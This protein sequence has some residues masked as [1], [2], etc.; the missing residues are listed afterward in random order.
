[1][2]IALEMCKEGFD[3]K[4]MERIIILG[5][6]QTCTEKI[7]MIGRLFRPYEGKSRVSV[8]QLLPAV[9][10][11]KSDKV[12]EENAQ[13]AVNVITSAMLY[14]DIFT[15]RILTPGE[16]KRT[17]RYGPGLPKVPSSLLT[18]ELFKDFLSVATKD[19]DETWR[20]MRP[21]LKRHGIEKA[22]W[23][24]VYDRLWKCCAVV[25]RRAMGLRFDVPFDVLKHTELQ[26]GIVKLM[27]GALGACD[28]K[29][30]REFVDRTY[31]TPEEWVPIAEDLAKKH[32]GVLPNCMW[33]IENGYSALDQA[34]RNYPELF[35]GFNQ[36]NK[37]GKT[38]K[39][40]L[41]DARR[42]T[43]NNEGLLPNYAWLR[44]NGYGSLNAA[45]RFYPSEFT[46]FKQAVVFKTVTEQIHDAEQLAKKQDG[47]LPNSKWL[48]KNGHSKLVSA[49]QNH[50]EEFAHI[51]QVKI[52]KTV[53]EHVQDAEQLAKANGGVLPNPSKLP[54]ALRSAMQGHCGAFSHLEQTKKFKSHEDH[55]RNARRLTKENGGKLPSYQSLI[56][57]GFNGLAQHIRIYPNDFARFKQEYRGGKSL[58]EHVRDA[59]RLAKDN[60]G[61]LPCCGWLS[62]N[63]YHGLSQAIRKTPA[64]FTE[65][66]QEILKGKSAAEHAKDARRLAKENGGRLPCGNWLNKNGYSGLVTAMK[67][68]PDKFVGIKQEDGNQLQSKQRLEK[69]VQVAEQL[70][71]RHGGTLPN[72]KW[73][74]T[75]GFRTLTRAMSKNPNLFA[76]IS[77][78]RIK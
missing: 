61:T 30:F 43:K 46:N 8:Y 17:D 76:H 49:M 70:A 66:K 21:V 9:V 55:V 19:Y 69:H 3:W 23:K 53:A 38:L 78:V 48:S 13:S 57:G 45:I 11:N 35:A 68:Q 4:P 32:G 10:K 12:L 39:E 28:L 59:R 56:D 36:K 74:E 44:D 31:R 58:D 60:G 65:I 7:K 71:V 37:K 62:N 51:E 50:P 73:L 72:P 1:V 63:G 6:R 16:P 33:L 18:V 20:H 29:A 24:P 64:F 67:K 25:S 15:P 26:E 22:I 34:M 14:E 54:V 42:L 5:G 41:Q 77:Q 47:I 40:H 75:N 52:F 2:I 27:T